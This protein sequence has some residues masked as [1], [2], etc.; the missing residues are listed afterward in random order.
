MKIYRCPRF[1]QVSTLLLA[2]ALLT[3]CVY[4][5]LYQI[6]LQLSEFDRYFSIE[7]TDH[8]K[9][10][11]KDPVMYREDFDYLSKLLPST[12]F[13]QKAG[14]ACFYRFYKIDGNQN[15]ADPE[16]EF[17]FK[18][19]FNSEDRLISWIYSPVFLK[20]APPEFLEVSLRSLGGGEINREKNQ[21][22]ADFSSV[23]KISA[24]LP[25]KS[26]TLLH[27]GDPLEIESKS[28]EEVL[29]Y[30]FRMYT[31]SIESGYEDRALSV[32][33]LTFDKL[34]AK[35]VKMAGKFAGLK[36][37]IDYRKYRKNT[38]SLALSNISR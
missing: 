17:F 4:W 14:K 10:N 18:L 6:K 19:N 8:F 35:L 2:S 38:E 29:I 27:L 34:S 33:K 7:V 23:E 21:L 26:E 20:I 16:V 15:P 32:I 37:S 24:D 13:A 9:V 25:V 28:E 36:I 31:P 11:F 30:H 12:C 22:K 5:R 3:G 1:Y